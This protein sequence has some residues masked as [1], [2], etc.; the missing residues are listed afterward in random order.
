[1]IN[2]GVAKSKTGF[3]AIDVVSFFGNAT[4]TNV[5]G[6]RVIGRIVVDGATNFVN[7][8][9]G[10]WLQ[11]IDLG[12]GPLAINTRGAPF[13]VVPTAAGA[14]IAVLDPTSFALADRALVNFTGGVSQILQDRFNGVAASA[15][16][17]VATALRR[18]VPAPP[19]RRRRRL[20]EFPRWQCLMPRTPAR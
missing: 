10:N 11:S 13:V 15:G 20:R 1:V 5:V 3:D 6:G 17:P 19:T 4:L 18:P 12:S 9:G 7:F 14:Q 8:V 2:S 16:G